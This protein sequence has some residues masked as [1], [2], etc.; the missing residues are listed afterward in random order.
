M[1]LDAIRTFIAVTETGNF[2]EAAKR[3]NVTQSTVSARIR[4]LEEGLGRTL[5]TRSKAGV[6][7][8]EPG[9]QFARY[10]ANM[11]RLWQRA[12][13]D[14]GLSHGFRSSFGLGSQV[15]LWDRLVLRWIPWMR[16][17][18]PDVALRVDA[19][20]SPTL[21][22]HV[23]DGVLDIAVMYQPR[24]RAGLAV[25]QLLV[26]TLV[27]VSTR[28]DAGQNW[29]DDYVFVHWGRDFEIAH[30]ENFPDLGTP[31][32][33]AGLGAL[34]LRYILEN[35]GS[36]YFPIRIARPYLT[37]GRLH[38]VSG[39]PTM[40]RTAYVVYDPSTPNRDVLD[41]ALLGLREV[42]AAGQAEDRTAV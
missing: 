17:A 19:D 23:A 33:S 32:V 12:Q 39:T 2:H 9:R 13:H 3:L 6:D 35:G 21:Q 24:R 41:R 4:A 8:T 22:R 34:G 31:A 29:R 37:D 5:F 38:R 14:V 25:E 10:A 28:P 27:M 18:A 30:T 7:M 36:A 26:E 11:M 20:N 16:Q 42:A 15:S 40:Q 1:Q